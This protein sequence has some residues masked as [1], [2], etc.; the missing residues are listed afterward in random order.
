VGTVQVRQDGTFSTS[1]TVPKNAQPGKYTVAVAQADGDEA[2]A[3]VT[4]NRAGGIGGIIKDIVD[5]L[6]DLLTGWF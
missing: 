6:W 1:V 5:W 3:T 4:V 2:T